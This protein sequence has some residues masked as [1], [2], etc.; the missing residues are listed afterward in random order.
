MMTSFEIG[1]GPLA[2]HVYKKT[3][4]SSVQSITLCST[5]ISM[6]NCI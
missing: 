4:S 2:V 1:G 5:Q 6:A 3:K